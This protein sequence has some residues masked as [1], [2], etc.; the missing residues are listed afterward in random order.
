MSSPSKQFFHLFVFAGH[1]LMKILLSS[2]VCEQRQKLTPRLI[3]TI[4][5]P[6]A[7]R[8]K[9][10]N[11]PAYT[12]AVYDERYSAVFAHCSRSQSRT[13]LAVRE[14]AKLTSLHFA[15]SSGLHALPPKRP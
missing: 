13:F 2:L 12:S 8:G 5:F 1:L 7:S 9:I 11:V 14:K 15:M 6:N 4:P 3:E 10:E